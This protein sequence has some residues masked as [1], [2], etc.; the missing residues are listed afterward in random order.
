M[1]GDQRVLGA[2]I[3]PRYPRISRKKRENNQ[4]LKKEMINISKYS[5][6]LFP[7]LVLLIFFLRNTV[8]THTLTNYTH[9]HP[10]KY[11]HATLPL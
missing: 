8:E 7:L 2:G 6:M 11:M 3:N 5:L 4:K 9:T 1:R 10:Y